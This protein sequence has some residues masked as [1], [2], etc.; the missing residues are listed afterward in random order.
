MDTVRSFISEAWPALK[1]M[2]AFAGVASFIGGTVCFIVAPS[3]TG[4]W[5]I[6]WKVVGIAMHAFTVVA[7]LVVCWSGFP[8]IMQNLALYTAV[9]V[10]VFFA[11]MGVWN[12]I[13]AKFPRL[14]AF[15]V[16]AVIVLF[17]ALVIALVFLCLITFGP[18]MFLAARA[19]TAHG[20]V[21][22]W[23]SPD[24]LFQ[25]L[26]VAVAA[27][28]L[29]STALSVFRRPR[30]LAIRNKKMTRVLWTMFLVVGLFWTV[31]SG[32]MIEYIVMLIVAA[33]LMV[34]NERFGY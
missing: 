12:L 26:L 7:V 24:L 6:A 34:L 29:G 27:C 15:L 20:A 31:A 23:L 25:M 14:Y 21:N 19:W 30:H 8:R 18:Q 32:F 2:L 28:A 9:L 22:I 10:F 4:R 33:V 16:K 1:C 17:W 3:R 13:K 11:V 5:G